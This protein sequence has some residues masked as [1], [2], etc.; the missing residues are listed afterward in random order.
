MGLDMYLSAE[1]YFPSYAVNGGESEAE[2]ATAQLQGVGIDCPF[3]VEKIVVRVA[4]W[5]KANAIHK[6]FVTNVQRGKDDCGIYHVSRQQLE[7]LMRLAKKALAHFN[8]G[9]PSAASELL[10]PEVVFF[11]G[12]TDLDDWYKDDLKLTVKQLKEALSKISKES[13]WNFYYQSSW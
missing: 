6:W 5:R 9:K 10:S 11:F 4:Y 8:A 7:E 3:P 13:G 2:K 12:S 1:K